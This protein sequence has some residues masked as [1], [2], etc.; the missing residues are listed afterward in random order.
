MQIAR[1]TDVIFILDC[2]NSSHQCFRQVDFQ[3]TLHMK[4]A[5]SC[6]IAKNTPY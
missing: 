2:D 4:F 3:G 5:F 6:E 1:N